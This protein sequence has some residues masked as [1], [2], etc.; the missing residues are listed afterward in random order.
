MPPIPDDAVVIS[1]Y[2]LMADYVPQTSGTAPFISKGVRRNN[3]S[4]DVFYD[5]SAGSI[6]FTLNINHA[7]GF[8]IGSNASQSADVFQ[9][10]LPAF[11]TKIDSLGY[12]DRRQIYVGS[13]SAETQTV[14]GSAYDAVAKMTNAQ[15]L[16]L[17]TFKSKNK[18][19][20]DGTIS[21]F[22]IASPIHTSSHY[23]TFETPF[24][25]E[26][27]GGDRNMEQ[28]NLVV[29]SDG[30]TWDEVTRDVSYI[31]NIVL[32]ERSSTN[33]WT[34]NDTNWKMEVQIGVL[35]GLTCFAKNE[36]WVHAY[37]RYICLKAG[38]YE[39][40]APCL[41]RSTGGHRYIKIN[42]VTTVGHH[43][44]SGNMTS[45]IM[46]KGAFNRGDYVEIYDEIHG[47]EW[48]TLYIK[49]V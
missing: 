8:Q 18:G 48:S 14:S 16:G 17:H 29:T 38:E 35:Q 47:N 40:E 39:F 7:G 20:T 41:V 37:D 24:L 28:T 36:Y 31:G 11:A 3:A 9:S 32:V 19:S 45:A 4:R 22:D 5:A 30:K 6:T 44:P 26:L 46:C 10:N 1:D 25:N 49:K 12:G 15:T 13:G 27:V 42:G 34:F 33:G 2:M 43:A 23:Q 21:Y